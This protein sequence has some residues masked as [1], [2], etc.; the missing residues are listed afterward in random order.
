MRAVT[1]MLMLTPL[2][3]SLQPGA[4]ELR[5]RAEARDELAENPPETNLD[6][7]DCS[8]EEWKKF[9]D[10]QVMRLMEAAETQSESIPASSVMG[11]SSTMQGVDTV[12]GTA[13]SLMTVSNTTGTLMSQRS[14]SSKPNWDHQDLRQLFDFNQ[15]D[16]AWKV[17]IIDYKDKILDMIGGEFDDETR[18]Q[19]VL[20]LI[21]PGNQIVILSGPTGCGKSQV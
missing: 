5:R 11:R 13:A 19:L 21:Y 7:Q 12:T 8:E 2:C 10:V 17:P 15:N 20:I 4:Q 1:V 9:R 18:N 16:F 3:I 14:I 6:L